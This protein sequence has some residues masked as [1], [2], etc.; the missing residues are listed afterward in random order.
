VYVPA[1]SIK[2]LGAQT[3]DFSRIR[4]KFANEKIVVFCLLT[5]ETIEHQSDLHARGLAPN[6]GIDEDPFTGSMQA[7]LVHAA[8]QNGYITPNKERIVTEQGNFIGR[9][10]F[11]VIDHDVT[12]G[13]VHVT[14]SAAQVFST[15]LEITE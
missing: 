4:E 2:L 5:N 11:A 10:G 14:A 9:P 7:G 1:A 3:F 12:N 15:K 13:E 8:K 6:I